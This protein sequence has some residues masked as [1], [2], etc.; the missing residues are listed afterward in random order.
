[1]QNKSML[2]LSSS[3]QTEAHDSA[4]LE[5]SA[6]EVQALMRRFGVRSE[7][8][9]EELEAIDLLIALQQDVQSVVPAPQYVPIAGRCVH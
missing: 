8:C 1:M 7:A 6:R 5:L 4:L 9:P 3:S 2:A